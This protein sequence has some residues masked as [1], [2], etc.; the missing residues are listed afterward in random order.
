MN[1][2]KEA[3][4]VPRNS[5]FKSRFDLNYFYDYDVDLSLVWSLISKLMRIYRENKEGQE[6]QL[7]ENLRTNNPKLLKKIYSRNF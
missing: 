3:E 1:L 6:N 2:I 5:E 4:C 7:L